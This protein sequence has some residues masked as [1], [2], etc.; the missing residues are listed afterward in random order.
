MSG[1]VGEKTGNLVLN[2]ATD[3]A[4]PRLLIQAPGGLRPGH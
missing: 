1:G 2:R 4:R 3:A